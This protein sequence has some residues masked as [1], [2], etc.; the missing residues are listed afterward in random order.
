MDNISDNDDVLND[1]DSYGTTSEEASPQSAAPEQKNSILNS[2]ILDYSSSLKPSPTNLNPIRNISSRGEFN[3]DTN[4]YFQ[5]NNNW[6]KTSEKA[7]LNLGTVQ[8]FV[9]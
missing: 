6:I 9:D 1:F 4:I 7:L 5:K 8:T 2:S 3:I